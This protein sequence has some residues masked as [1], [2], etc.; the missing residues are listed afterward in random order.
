M[1]KS[2][3]RNGLVFGTLFLLIFVAFAG[4]SMNV[5]A[6]PATITVP[7]D[8]STI[9]AAVTAANSGDTVYVR[10]GTYYEHVTIGKSLTL[11]GEDRDTTIVNGGGSG[12]TIYISADHV[13]LESLKITNGENGVRLP[14]E[15][16]ES[17]LTIRNVIIDSNA[18]CGI[19]DCHTG[20][21]W[22]IEDCIISNNG[23]SGFHQAHQF[24]HSVIRNCEIFGNGGGGFEIGWAS[25]W[26][27]E[28]CEIYSNIGNGIA[29]DTADYG[30][31]KNCDI[32][33]NK[34]G[35]NFHGWGSY[36]NKIVGNKIHSNIE[37][38]Q[39]SCCYHRGNIFI[40][41]QIYDNEYGV[42]IR[43]TQQY[44]LR[45]NIFYHNDFIDNTVNAR[46]DE[47]RY[48]NVWDNGYPSGGNYWDD[49]TG[50]DANSDG[51]GDTPYVINVK[52]KDNYPLMKPWNN[53]PPVANAGPDQTVEQ[54]S[55]S[56]VEVTLDGSG[57]SDPD[58]DELTYSWTWEGGSATG[59]NPQVT[60]PLGTTTVTLVVNDGTVDSDPDTVDIT[61]EDTTPPVITTTGTP[62]VLWPPN[63]KY[64]TVK[65]SDFVT[66][67]EDICDAN[68]DIDDVIITSVSS[69][70]PED[71]K[72]D[73]NTKD[74]I[75]IVDSQTVK[76]RAERQ[77]KG[78]GRVYTINFEV[79]DGEGN[80][81]YGSFQIWV[82]H[83]KKDTAIDDG[84]SAGYTV[85]V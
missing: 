53:Q 4:I 12:N 11:Q 19:R 10:V 18:N 78:N 52:N 26:S 64:H 74:D 82:P 34:N 57:S 48:I 17:H 45:D 54:N 58:E 31:I 22:V 62:I 32:Y 84:A 75:V 30:T 41:N 72:G 20:G 63:H 67:V 73:G 24:H 56:G 85:Y 80:T 59:V 51:I 29:I 6:D 46:V 83:N 77:G 9:Q 15:V 8:Y 33:S 16:Y 71:A 39:L 65:I 81:A 7:D 44:P 79:T 50:I 60:F 49:Y 36:Y 66:S 21:Y 27:V 14:S 37:G 69:D 35:I 1:L 68:V 70:E 5:S 55:Y 76:L 40:E 13:T 47:D 3:I 61:V 25:Y 28:N 2:I 43:K 23:G 38:I 42:Y